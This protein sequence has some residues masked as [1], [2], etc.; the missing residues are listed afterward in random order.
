MKDNLF[1]QHIAN[2]T[3]LAALYSHHKNLQNSQKPLVMSFHG[4][5][6]TGKNYLSDRIVKHLYK[7]GDESKFVHKYRG[8]I[9]FPLVSDVELYRITLKKQI[10][11]AVRS[12]P[13]SLFVFD[14]VDKMPDGVFESITS[15]LDHHSHV[16]GVNFRQ[17]IFIFLSN[18][19]GTELSD[20][21]QDMMEHGKYREQ[22]TIYN[23]E[24]I[25]E[26]GAYNVKGGLKNAGMIT[27]SLID[28]YV[29]FLPM[30]KRHIEQCVVAEFKRLGVT[31]TEEQIT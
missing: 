5:P 25:A 19:G 29:P 15:L 20:A 31:P 1:G 14:E 2:H 11:D 8:R 10:V 26:A 18:A 22:T 12:C 13:R 7:L 4:T 30:E 3:V 28:H 23:F 24:K 27:S 17:S 21:L 9:D 16:N 6:G